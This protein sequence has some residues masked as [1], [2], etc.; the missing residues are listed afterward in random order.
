M[1]SLHFWH[2]NTAAGP[3]FERDSVC[4]A[5]FAIAYTPG[6]LCQISNGTE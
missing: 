5:A 4:H 2:V 6:L 1:A 3:H